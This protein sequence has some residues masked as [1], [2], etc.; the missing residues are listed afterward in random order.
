MVT[1]NYAV[2]L[3]FV[4]IKN[5]GLLLNGIGYFLAKLGNRY[6]KNSAAAATAFRQKI[7]GAAA[8]RCLFTK[9]APLPLVSAKQ[10]ALPLGTAAILKKKKV[11]SAKAF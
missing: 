4:V 11:K 5:F 2:F 9:A 10:P 7:S 8:N 1:K 3:N 6:F